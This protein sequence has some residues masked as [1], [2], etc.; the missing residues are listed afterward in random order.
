MSRL[1][2]WPGSCRVV[3]G[4]AVVKLRERRMLPQAKWIVTLTLN[5]LLSEVR[6]SREGTARMS[7]HEK[8]S[9]SQP[10]RNTFIS[11][12]LYRLGVA[13]RKLLGEAL[14]WQGQVHGG[15][16]GREEHGPHPGIVRWH[17]GCQHA[18]GEKEHSTFYEYM[19]MAFVNA[20]NLHRH[21]AKCNMLRKPETASVNSVGCDLRLSCAPLPL[22]F[23][24][25]T[26]LCFVSVCR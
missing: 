3:R 15:G 18:H 25:C 8:S 2:R 23:C 21:G 20:A 17:S 11:Y 26:G 24:R 6:Y 19:T 14:R 12:V 1:D 9:R 22:R 4:G 13:A 5:V 16:V 10:V 7:H